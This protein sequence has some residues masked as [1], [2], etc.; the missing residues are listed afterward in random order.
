MT[1]QI[2]TFN[3]EAAGRALDVFSRSLVL[4]KSPLTPLG[5]SC[6]GFSYLVFIPGTLCTD[7][8]FF[9]VFFSTA[10]PFLAVVPKFPYYVRYSFTKVFRAECVYKFPFLHNVTQ[11]PRN[12]KAQSL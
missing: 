9:F 11:L 7:I 10:L 1:M 2:N 12:E 4:Q 5:S 6:L 3:N 8:G